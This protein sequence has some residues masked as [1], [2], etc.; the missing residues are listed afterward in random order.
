MYSGEKRGAPDDS[1]APAAH[2]ASHKAAAQNPNRRWMKG[3]VIIKWFCAPPATGF[4]PLRNFPMQSRTRLP[5]AD[6]EPQMGS[7]GKSRRN[8]LWH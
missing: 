3:V 1:S 4:N 8:L 2:N 5:T 7:R 6:S